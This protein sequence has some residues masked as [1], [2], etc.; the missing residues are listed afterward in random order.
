M[1]SS[2]EMSAALSAE[3]QKRRDAVLEAI[4]DI[5][6]YEKAFIESFF[7]RSEDKVAGYLARKD[8]L[9]TLSANYFSWSVER[10]LWA[11]IVREKE[12]S[13][14]PKFPFAAA[15]DKY[16]PPYSE[17][18]I[19]HLAE[20]G[21]ES[22]IAGRLRELEHIAFGQPS[23]EQRETPA[24]LKRYTEF[25]KALWTK[26]FGCIARDPDE[27][28]TVA[29]RTAFLLGGR[30]VALIVITNDEKQVFLAL[31]FDKKGE[32]ENPAVQYRF[33][34]AWLDLLCLNV[35][36]LSGRNVNILTY[37]DELNVN[38][39]GARF[40]HVA[41]GTEK[42][43]LARQDRIH[44]E[45]R[46]ARDLRPDDPERAVILLRFQD[47]Q[48]RAVAKREASMIVPIGVSTANY[49][50]SFARI[51]SLVRDKRFCCI[52]K[53]ELIAMVE[54]Q[55]INL[56]SLHVKM[57]LDR[58]ESPREFELRTVKD[59]LISIAP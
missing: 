24:G 28:N 29:Q 6:N 18:F 9:P 45:V 50:A 41:A 32:K 35:Q 8:F 54:T 17:I 46:K 43:L 47:R 26:M 25:L 1:S 53:D 30:E 13:N 36:W 33:Q 4:M 22:D 20:K 39:L 34:N 49:D 51:V 15:P 12:D 23:G 40:L 44:N 31:D 16:G 5:T 55:A 38:H 14:S 58:S 19:S 21:A 57:S 42:E 10:H 2:W 56:V 52:P 3:E 48:V 27:T 59:H 7:K 37:L 11:A